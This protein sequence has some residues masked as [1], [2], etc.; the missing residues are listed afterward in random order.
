MGRAPAGR[1]GKYEGSL[2][3]SMTGDART[4]RLRADFGCCPRNMVRDLSCMSHVAT[5][6]STA[7]EGSKMKKYCVAQHD[8]L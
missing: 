8:T 2:L 6:I 1:A 7:V 5:P 4:L 3:M